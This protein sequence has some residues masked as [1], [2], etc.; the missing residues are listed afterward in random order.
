MAT[1]VAVLPER[2]GPCA[3]KGYK[4]YDL[5]KYMGGE[6]WKFTQTEDFACKPASFGSQLSRHAKQKGLASQVR[7]RGSHLFFQVTGKQG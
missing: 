1:Q 2:I 5:E 3:F 7:V 6:A 4:K